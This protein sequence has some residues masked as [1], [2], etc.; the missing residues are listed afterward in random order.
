MRLEDLTCNILN[1]SNPDFSCQIDGSIWSVDLAI[2]VVSAFIGAG[3]TLA[4]VWFTLS[5]QREADARQRAHER[6]ID[7]EA[8]ATQIE[9]DRRLRQERL[10][11]E[12]L[13]LLRQQSLGRSEEARE[14][15]KRLGDGTLTRTEVS[16]FVQGVAVLMGGIG[17]FEPET[18]DLLSLAVRKVSR[19]KGPV[20]PVM[21]SEALR[22]GL[23]NLQLLLEIRAIAPNR[24]P[25]A[26]GR[27][28]QA[29]S[30]IE[31]D[32]PFIED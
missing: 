19:N 2:A 31:R 22:C 18:A 17:E 15:G 4:A 6:K 27:Q 21:K 20:D 5:H 29:R 30:A 32:L 8:R 13:H 25:A 24:L 1:T 3:A 12:K 23:L 14:L 10:D 16:F 9:Q 28:E 26:V 7:A 11:D